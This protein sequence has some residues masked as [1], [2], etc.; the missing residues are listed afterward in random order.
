[1]DKIDQLLTKR[2]ERIYPTKQELEKVLRSGKKIKLYQGFDPSS[3]NLHIGHLVG[4]LKLAEFQEMGHEVIFLIG[5][6]TGMIGDPTGKGSARRKLTKE[7]VLTNAREYRKQAEKVLNF[8]GENGVKILFNSSW[9]EKLSFGDVLELFSNVTVNQLV[10]R[11]MFQER[12]K[13]GGEIW[14]HE[15]CYPIIQ[16][17]DSVAMKIDLEIGGSDQMFNMMMGRHLVKKILNKEKYVLTTP[18]LCDEKGN[19][20]GKTE[21][22]AINLADK[23]EEF[24]GKVMAIPDEAIVP[25]FEMI[26]RVVDGEVEKI[27]KEMKEGVNPMKVKKKLAYELTKMLNGENEAKRAEEYFEKIV[28]KKDLPNEVGEVEI[29]KG[30]VDVIKLMIK[31]KLVRSNKEGKRL[32]EQGGV[33]INGT[34][35]DTGSLTIEVV[36]GMILK[37]GKRK[38]IKLLVR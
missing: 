33:S 9:N 27:R 16:G 4:L 36:D 38:Y 21:G 1:M 17:N 3:A 7:E 5:D 32:V 34:R 6:F 31:N 15:L 8:E 19:K 29:E 23:P 12:F 20:V 30:K 10:E 18:L 25:C 37:I 24:Y 26:T 11:D 13:K 28:Q 35:L 22:N 14:F 2:V